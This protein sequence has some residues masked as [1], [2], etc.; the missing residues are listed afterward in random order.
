MNRPLSIEQILN[1]LRDPIWQFVGIIL[2]LIALGFTYKQLNKK[3]LGYSVISKSNILAVPTRFKNKLEIK[4]NQEIINSLY[5]VN[6]ILRNTGNMAIKPDDFQ[7]FIKISGGDNKKIISCNVTKTNPKRLDVR[8]ALKN[9]EKGNY[10]I[11]EPLLLNSKDSFQIQFLF[12]EFDKILI[13]ARIV[14]IKEV[15]E[16]GNNLFADFIIDSIKNLLGGFFLILLAILFLA[17]LEALAQQNIILKFI[18]Y[19]IRVGLLIGF[20]SLVI[21]GAF[22]QYKSERNKDNMK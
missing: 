2:T 11:I 13:E 22:E 21:Y 15:R 18:V 5:V 14:D 7:E 16:Y 17:L 20:F 8:L 10:V 9:D 1:I 4:Y 3:S 12:E 19:V 6:I